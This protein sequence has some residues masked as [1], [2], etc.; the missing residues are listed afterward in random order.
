MTKLSGVIPGFVLNELQSVQAKYEINTV[1]RLAH[2]L[3]QCKHE[4][5][6]FTATMEN[7][8]YSAVG[9]LSVFP[10]YFPDQ[11]MAKHYARQPEKIAN[12]VYAN[13]MG[14]GDES[15][16]DGWKHRGFGYIQL[17]GKFNQELF[18]CD[19]EV[20]IEPWQIADPKYALMSA[21]WFWKNR[22][23][24]ELADKGADEEVIKK[25][26]KVVNGGYKGLPDRI[27]AFNV[28]YSF[29]K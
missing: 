2:F 9:L 27:K 4:S 14:N 17:T 25:I 13:R 7:L 11:D 24:N 10:K 19:L 1:L 18:M 21:G 15:S 22:G 8:N 20:A 5:A 29:L 12:R 3:S 26:T 28:I 6:N 23:L 16:G